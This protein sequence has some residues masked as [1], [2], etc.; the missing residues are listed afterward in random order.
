M[1]AEN[2]AFQAEV[3]Q[4]LRLVI[5]SLYSNK[6]IFL[7]ELLSNASDAIDRRRFLAIEK[8]ELLAED[9]R[10]MIRLIPDAEAGT[11]TIWDNGLG[12][13]ESELK[14]HLGT[15]AFS[16]SRRFLES[17]QA[18]SEK[19]QDLPKLIGQFGVGFYS[20]YL[21]AERV[22]VVSRKAGSEHAF[23]WESSGEQGFSIEPAERDGAGTSVT[24]KLKEDQREYLEPM[25]L[26]ELVRRYSDY[27][28]H[29]IELVKG[30]GE[31]SGD[32]INRASALWQRQP[33]DV[34]PDE[35][36]EF[37]KHLAR[38]W[39]APLAHRHFHIEGTQMF[40]GLLFVPKRAPL[41]LF[42]P[43]PS[44]GVRL[45]VR[46]VMVMENAEELVPRWLR[47]VKGVIDSEDLPL[48]VSRELLQD[49]RLVKSMRKQ[50]VSQTLDL[51]QEVAKDRPDDYLGF[52][53]SFGPVLKEGLHFEPEL[54]AQLLPLLR[55]ESAALAKLVSL[56]EYLSAM[57]EGQP[58]IYYLLSTQKSAALAPHLEQARARGYDVLLLTDAVDPFVM[59]TLDEYAGKP[60]RSLSAVELDLDGN[61]QDAAEKPPAESSPLVERSARVLEKQVLEVK[62]S[63]RLTESP[64]CLVVQE[65]GLPPH[66]ERLLRASGRELPASRR[67]LE[68]NLKHPLVQRVAELEARE[69]G[70]ERVADWIHLLYDQALLAEGSPPEDPAAFAKRLSR[71]MT[72]AASQELA[73]DKAPAGSSVPAGKD[74]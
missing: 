22:S 10:L 58:G 59:E 15:V 54:K 25:R 35:Y 53:K 19:S 20:A 23:R 61:K 5:H 60:F 66:L 48:N 3:S 44:H 41:D 70:S 1:P 45:H 74:V 63:S 42:D 32:V 43:N 50:V 51:L 9:E 26:R 29:P 21:V 11:L 16:G 64:A 18:S 47:F 55:F 56:D 24:L 28:P 62:P 13:D 65:G 73:A 72:A 12:M 17:V 40:S 2:Y 71:V 38:D 49:S 4:V 36:V 8:P 31:A 33:K 14:E 46:R 30:P 37:Y 57:P 6:E 68:L 27:V 69:P 52:W 7:R 39:E 34:P 67:V